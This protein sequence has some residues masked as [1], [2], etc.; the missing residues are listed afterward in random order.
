[1][2]TFEQLREALRDD[3]ERSRLGINMDPVEAEWMVEGEA[4]AEAR[5]K[6]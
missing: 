3:A 2:T 5:Y 1:M 4:V 6:A